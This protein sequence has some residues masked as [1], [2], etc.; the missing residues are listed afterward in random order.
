M[1]IAVP[2]AAA[3]RAPCRCYSL[4]RQRGQ[5]E[6]ALPC[7]GQRTEPEP[8]LDVHLQNT[9][10]VEFVTSL[11]QIVSAPTWGMEGERCHPSQGV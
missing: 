1:V 11:N 4:P 8:R 2:G 3:S 6:Q 9:D 10:S 5:Q 7:L